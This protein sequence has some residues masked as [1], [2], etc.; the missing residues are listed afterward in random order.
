MAPD[1]YYRE[2]LSTLEKQKLQL[3][4]RKKILGW[5]RLG[6]IIATGL[7]IYLLWPYGWLYAVVPSAVLLVVF[8]RVVFIDIGNNQ[9]IPVPE[10]YSFNFL[11]QRQKNFARSCQAK[12]P[13]HL[14]TGSSSFY[15]K[16]FMQQIINHP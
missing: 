7:A 15:A 12:Q 11:L 13:C 5:C 16:Q 4:G 8:M 3:L 9:V 14:R 1:I 2:R 6:L 10:K